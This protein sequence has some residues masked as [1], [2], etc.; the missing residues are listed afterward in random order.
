MTWAEVSTKRPLRCVL[1]NEGFS[2]TPLWRPGLNG[3]VL[4]WIRRVIQYT[5]VPKT[6]F[7]GQVFEDRYLVYEFVPKTPPLPIADSSNR[8]YHLKGFK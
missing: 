8:G 4:N 1:Y 7:E 2:P 3:R 6:L 5:V